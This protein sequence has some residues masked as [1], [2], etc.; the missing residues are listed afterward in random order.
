MKDIVAP[1][2]IPAAAEGLEENISSTTFA[3]AFE[4]VQLVS[5]ALLIRTVF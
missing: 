5:L 2:V 4:D 1:Q 3:A